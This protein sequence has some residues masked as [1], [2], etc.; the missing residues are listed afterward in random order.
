MNWKLIVLET[1]LAGFAALSGYAV[2]Q[3]GIVGLFEALLANAAT[4]TAFADLVI[5]LSL[6]IIWMIGD[7]RQR[8]VASLP[9]VVTTLLFGSV[10]P[11]LYLIR[12]E[13]SAARRPATLATSGQRVPA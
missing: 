6:A 2:W 1:V 9:Y 4:V 13:R 12:R 10:G 5:A 7:A 11:L 8:G 3:H